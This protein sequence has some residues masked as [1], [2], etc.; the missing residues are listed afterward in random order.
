M[1]LTTRRNKTI[2]HDII[3]RKVTVNSIVVTDSWRGYNAI[4]YD[5]LR[6]IF[7]NENYFVNSNGYHTNKIEAT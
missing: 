2:I 1:L 4:E 5:C 7:I 3:K 6:E